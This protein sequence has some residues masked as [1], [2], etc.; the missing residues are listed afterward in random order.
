MTT[1]LDV[2]GLKTYFSIPNGPLPHQRAQLRAVDDVSFTV[3]KG[4]TLSIVGESGCGKSTLGRT[5]L[6]FLK[7]TAGAVWLDGH[8]I[9]DMPAVQLRRLRR[10]MQVVFQDPASSLSP[11]MRVRDIIAEPLINFAI[12]RGRAAI[13]AEVAR[14]IELVGLSADMMHRYPHEFSGGQRQRIAIARAL[15]PKPDLIIC[16]EAVSA[17]DVS[18]KA[19]IVNLLSDLQRDLNLALVFISHDL[20]IVEHLTDRVAVM[21][22]GAIVELADRRSLFSAPSHPYT[23]ALLSA[24][25]PPNMA[26]RPA[27]MTLRGEV[28]SPIDPP[29]GCRFHT[30]CPYVFERCR[31]EPPRMR[32]RSA[33]QESACHLDELPALA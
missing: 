26:P 9:S 30:R 10:Q 13:D 27:R 7:P 22:L 28:P 29:P 3:E 14:L 20:A 16:D 19:Q 12:V 11:R 25:L 17:L 8:R 2:S 31:I 32:A 23:R 6:R 18:S 5:I 21:Y 15:A 24:V 1:I 33:T 4:E